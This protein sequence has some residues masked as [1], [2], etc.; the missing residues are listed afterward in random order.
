MLQSEVVKMWFITPVRTRLLL[1]DE[2]KQE[3][4]SSYASHLVLAA[5]G[6]DDW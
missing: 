2:D 6:A 4:K 5:S 1:D 3:M